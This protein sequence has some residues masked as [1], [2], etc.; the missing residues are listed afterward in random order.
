MPKIDTTQIP[1]FDSM[2]ADEKVAAL[3][4]VEIPEKVDLSKYVPKET[5]DKKASEAADATKKLR[6][7][8]TSGRSRRRSSP[9]SRFFRRIRERGCRELIS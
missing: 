1:D 7:A 9:L 8:A 4:G 5:F 2:T 6:A 3:L